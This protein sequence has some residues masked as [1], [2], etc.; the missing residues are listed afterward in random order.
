M[1]T[2][3]LSPELQQSTDLPELLNGVRFKIVPD[4]TEQ[5]QRV[6]CKS[7]FSGVV[8]TVQPGVGGLLTKAHLEKHKISLERLKKFLTLHAH[9][10][11]RRYLP[12]LKI[13]DASMTIVTTERGQLF[14][15]Q[16]VIYHTKFPIDALGIIR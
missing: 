16:V 8:L 14:H 1:T 15:V 11:H 5:V 10:M 4:M 9:W 13:A 3:H 6:I 12:G 7:T 2:T